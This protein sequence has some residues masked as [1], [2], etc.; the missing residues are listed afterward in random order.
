MGVNSH[1]LPGDVVCS[2]GSATLYSKL[3]EDFTVTDFEFV[4]A[5]SFNRDYVSLLEWTECLVISCKKLREKSVRMFF[6]LASNM[7][8]GWIYDYD[9]IPLFTKHEVRQ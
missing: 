3:I 4:T 7:K 9:V 2:I 8:F 6:V 5:D 1:I